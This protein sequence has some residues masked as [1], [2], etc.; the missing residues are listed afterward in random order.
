M[1]ILEKIK[2]LKYYFYLFFLFE[3]FRKL[4]KVPFRFT[5]FLENFLLSI[6][7]LEIFFIC[8]TALYEWLFIILFWR[9]SKIVLFFLK[10]IDKS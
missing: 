3:T 9:K 7:D 4:N 2:K 1:Y 8:Y 6:S 10:I 5:K